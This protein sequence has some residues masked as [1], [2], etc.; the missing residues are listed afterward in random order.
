MSQLLCIAFVMYIA[1]IVGRGMRKNSP[2]EH[3]PEEGSKE[4]YSE[5]SQKIDELNRCRNG[6][7]EISEMIADIT[8][9]SPGRVAKTVSVKI[10]ESGREYNFLLD[11]EDLASELMLELLNSERDDL[12]TSLRSRI[13]KIS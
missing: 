3:E 11:G 4:T 2:Q 1:V 12:N 5:L 7:D 13:K 8:S 9:C 10:L 6:I